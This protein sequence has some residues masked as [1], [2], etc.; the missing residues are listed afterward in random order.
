MSN[1]SRRGFIA[2]ITAVAGSLVAAEAHAAAP[3]KETG[4]SSEGLLAGRP[5]FQPRTVMPRRHQE[6][7]AFLSR[8]Q[9]DSHYAEYVHDVER[10]KEV[11]QRLQDANLD[12]T[13]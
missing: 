9:L 10:L 6:L 1:L 12:A 11:E 8:V 4:L 2:S 3:P 13:R 5:G 7:P